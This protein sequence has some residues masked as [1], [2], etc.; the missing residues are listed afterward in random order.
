MNRTQQCLSHPKNFEPARVLEV[1]INENTDTYVVQLQ[2]NSDII[3]LKKDQIRD[4]DP[5]APIQTFNDQSSFPMSLWICDS[6]KVTLFLPHTV[7][8]PKQGYFCQNTDESWYFKPGKIKSAKTKPIP[9]NDFDTLATSLVT[10]KKLF[11]GWKHR[12]TVLT[13][14][15]MRAKSNVIAKHV[16]AR[17]LNNLIKLSL[18][19]HHLLNVNDK[20]IWDHL[21]KEEYDGLCNL[22][23]WEVI[24]EEEYKRLRPT[25]GH[26]LPTMAILTIKTDGDGNPV[27]GKYCIV[28]LGNLDPHNWSKSTASLWCFHKLN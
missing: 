27:R 17:G 9:L 15:S 14:R 23:M 26:V 20:D 25:M 8:E 13:A 12:C 16:S 19:K 28:L 10:N 4:M 21:Y 11:Q 22:D 6:A 1:P 24:T 5:H 7:Q 2:D 3:E 18:T